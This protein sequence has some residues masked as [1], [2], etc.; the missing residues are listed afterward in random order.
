MKSSHL[1][2]RAGELDAADR[3]DTFI[4]C[5]GFSEPHEEEG[6]ADDNGLSNNR[7]LFGARIRCLPACTA[8]HLSSNCSHV[9]VPP[10]FYLHRFG[11]HRKDEKLGDRMERKESSRSKMEDTQ[12]SEEETMRMQLERER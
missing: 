10:S 7:E 9:H 2:G 11:K 4:S 5:W 8:P 1:F 12:V 6:L 3:A